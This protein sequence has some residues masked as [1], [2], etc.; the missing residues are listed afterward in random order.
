MERLESINNVKC[1]ICGLEF[2][3]KPYTIKTTKNICCSR[4]CSSELRKVTMKGVNNHQFG[5]FGELNGSYEG[6]RHINNGYT[7][8]LSHNHPFKNKANLVMEHRLIAEKHLLTDENK[9]VINGKDYLNP[10]FVVHHIDGVRDNNEVSNLQIMLKSEHTRY[11]N[12]MNPHKRNN[13]NGRFVK[14]E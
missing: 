11:H 3:V 10:K 6:G 1:P 12:L 5:L 2:R 8:I 7:L 4:K 13:D 14:G 9:I